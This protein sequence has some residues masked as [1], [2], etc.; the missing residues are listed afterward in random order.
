MIQSPKFILVDPCI[1]LHLTTAKHRVVRF[2]N[3]NHVG[4][5][6]QVDNILSPVR[7]ERY[8]RVMGGEIFRLKRQV[9]AGQS[10]RSCVRLWSQNLLQECRTPDRGVEVWYIDIDGI[11][12]RNLDP[13][14]GM[15]HG[16]IILAMDELEE[17]C[18]TSISVTYEATAKEISCSMGSDSRRGV[19]GVAVDQ[20]GS[21]MANL[22][23]DE[24]SHQ[25]N[26]HRTLCYSPTRSTDLN[27][28]ASVESTRVVVEASNKLQ[29]SYEN[30]GF[31]DQ[32]ASLTGIVGKYETLI[33]GLGNRRVQTESEEV[34]LCQRGTGRE[35]V[36][37]SVGA[38]INQFN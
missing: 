34:W 6:I 32:L 25:E 21:D 36:E 20:T 24:Q 31:T 11:V 26:P 4:S 7:G 28:T 17:T 18:T 30:P 13:K 16:Q 1:P 19:G 37:S 38:T 27:L 8:D 23:A 5:S 2:F 14:Q 33:R 12:N 15:G 29:S 22:G 9:F 10:H 3:R 35:S